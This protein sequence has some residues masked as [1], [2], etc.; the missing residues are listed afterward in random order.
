M[1]RLNFN[2]SI[3]FPLETN[4]LSEMQTAWSIL[5][6]LGN[7]AGNFTILQGCTVIGTTVSDG[8]VFINGEVIEFKGGQL[9]DNVIIVETPTVLEFED[10]SE[11]EVIY[12]R[13]ATFGVAT[14][15]WPWSDFKRGFETKQIS[16]ALGLKEDKTTVTALVE[17]ILA[18]EA[19]PASNI[20]IG[21][22]AVWGQPVAT[23]PAGWTEYVPLRGRM[24][25]GLDTSDPYFETLLAPGGSKTHINTIP[26]MATHGHDWNYSTEGDD[27]ASGGSYSEFTQKPGGIAANNSQN[28]IG[29]TGGGQEYSIMNPY[30]VVLYIQYVG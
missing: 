26:E 14:T 22:I 4:I 9:Q 1:N 25:V 17:R 8:V 12:T 21:L 19:R 2:Q 24:P 15:Q 3:G 10:N 29:K 11:K 6:A 27:G 28:P 13:H 5:N 18:L 7:I 20:P 16:E 23:I 30:R